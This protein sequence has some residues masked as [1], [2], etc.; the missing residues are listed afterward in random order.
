[1][2]DCFAGRPPV[3]RA[4]YDEI[5]AHLAA[6]GP[7]HIDAVRVGVFLKSERK[8][9]EVRPNAR[10]LALALVLRRSADDSRISRKIRI[11]GDR[12]VH[13]VK[14]MS[15]SDVDDQVRACVS[16]AYDEAST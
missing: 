13:F 8:L 1:V 5:V 2:D 10:S 4:I 14:L 9:A 3:Q 15:L 6:Q 11:S 16:E 7:L 12:T